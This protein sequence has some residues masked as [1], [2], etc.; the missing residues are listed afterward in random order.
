MLWLNSNAAQ[1][2]AKQDALARRTAIAKQM[3][4]ALRFSTTQ[5][6]WQ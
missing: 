6:W 3:R 5:A 2:Q 4:A 1:Q